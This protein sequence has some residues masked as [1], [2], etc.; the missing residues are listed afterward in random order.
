P[1]PLP[2]TTLFRS[3]A[4]KSALVAGQMITYT[5]TATNTGNVSLSNV[6]I[7][8]TAFTGTGPAPVVGSCTPPQPATLAP[9]DSMVCQATYLVNQADV[10]QGSVD[11][12]EIGTAN[13]CTP[14]T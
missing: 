13:P 5:F 4:D 1:T 12:T 6:S 3:T 2:Y 7:A 9:T 11:N 10:D 14:A 8:E